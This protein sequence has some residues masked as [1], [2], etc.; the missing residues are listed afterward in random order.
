MKSV[1]YKNL[2]LGISR[3]TGEVEPHSWKTLS[4]S[5]ELLEERVGGDFPSLPRRWQIAST[6]KGCGAR[7]P[8]FWSVL[9]AGFR[10]PALGPRLLSRAG[11]PS[12]E[13]WG[14]DEPLLRSSHRAAQGPVLQGRAAAMVM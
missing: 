4:A 14:R 9:G 10:G 12:L 6:H 1:P 3:V 11:E 2:M 8:V 7:L 13:Q 5:L